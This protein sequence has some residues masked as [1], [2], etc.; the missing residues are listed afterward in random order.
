[1]PFSVQVTGLDALRAK[2]GPDLHDKHVRKAMEASLR[3]IEDLARKLAPKDTGALRASITHKL[4]RAPIGG[5]YGWVGSD[6]PYAAAVH[7]G[8]RAGA[9]Q[10]PSG[11]IRG[12]LLRKGADPRLAFVVARAIGRRGIA[13]RRFLADAF[14]RSRRAVDKHL[15][16]AATA[17]ERAWSQK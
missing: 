2:V 15:D 5:S 14:E 13:P 9:R 10:P 6:L 7:E 3:D 11:P 1:V 16:D 17:I 4:Q 8:R 12:W